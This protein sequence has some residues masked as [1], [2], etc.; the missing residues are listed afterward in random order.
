MEKKEKENEEKIK[1]REKDIF[2]QDYLKFKKQFIKLFS[3]L[4][5]KFNKNQTSK[6]VSILKPYKNPFKNFNPIKHS[7]DSNENIYITKFKPEEKKTLED[8]LIQIKKDEK[9]SIT[10][11]HIT[12]TEKNFSYEDIFKYFL[13]EEISNKKIIEN[14]TSI[15]KLLKSLPNGFEIVGKIAHMNL[16]DEYLKYKYFI[17]IILF[18]IFIIFT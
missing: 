12:L 11:E 16:R 17:S 18:F 10:E 9:Y 14:E 2:L 4:G 13:E 3:V 7:K 6:F 5:V 8:I 15:N 1:E